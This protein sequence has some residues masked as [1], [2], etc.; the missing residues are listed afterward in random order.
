MIISIDH[1]NK[2]MKTPHHVFVSGLQRSDVRPAL[3]DEYMLYKDQYYTLSQDRL[4]YRRDKSQDEDYFI[5]TLFALAREILDAGEYSALDTIPVDLLVGLPPAHYSAQYKEFETYF[6]RGIIEFEYKDMP[7]AV[8]INY[9]T[10]YPQAYAAAMTVYKQLRQMPKSIIIDIGGFTTDYLIMKNG[11]ADM[12]SCKSLE[13]GVIMLYNRVINTVNSAH[14]LLL[15]EEDIDT[16]LRGQSQVLPAGIQQSVRQQA[17]I[18]ADEL[19]G[20]LREQ[21]YDLRVMRPVFVGGGS[22]LLKPFLEKNSR[23][24]SPMF[25]EDLCANAKGYEILH[26]IRQTTGRRS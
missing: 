22:L 25:V 8:K 26:Q 6:R 9:V 17:T 5:L 23:V 19:V 1:G 16:V 10:A 12:N 14:D 18:F 15:E 24:F 11:I 3:C 20:Q 2:Q 7:F 21:K 4:A 13:H